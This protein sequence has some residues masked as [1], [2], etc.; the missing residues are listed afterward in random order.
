MRFGFFNNII[1]KNQLI[2][3]KFK[4]SDIPYSIQQINIENFNSISTFWDFCPSW[5]NSFDSIKRTAKG[6]VSIGVFIENS[7]IGYCVFEPTSGDI[8]QIAVDKQNRRKGVASLLLKEIVR[9]NE[10]NV[11]KII[12]TDIS[13]SSITKF[14]KSKNI[15]ITGMQFEMIKEI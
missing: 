11:V 2:D 4:T 7:L 9:L 13:C 8:T 6:F 15:G 1:Q 10:N 12:N 14:L 3:K 5:Q